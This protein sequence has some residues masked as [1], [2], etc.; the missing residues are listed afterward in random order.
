MGRAYKDKTFAED[1]KRS[2]QRNEDRLK[3]KDIEET[4]GNKLKHVRGKKES[5]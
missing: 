4:R 5:I 2:K 3:G 1:M